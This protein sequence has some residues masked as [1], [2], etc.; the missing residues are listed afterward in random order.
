MVENTSD[1]TTLCDILSRPNPVSFREFIATSETDLISR[2]INGSSNPSE[3]KDLDKGI[4][5]RI[6]TCKTRSNWTK[7]TGATLHRG[8][9]RRAEDIKSMG[10]VLSPTVK[11]TSSGMWI[12]GKGKYKS[13]YK[14]QSWTDNFNIARKFSGGLMFRG[15]S[16][17][18][19]IKPGYS[20]WM[21]ITIP[22]PDPD[23]TFSVPQEWSFLGEREVVLFNDKTINVDVSLDLGH[24]VHAVWHGYEKAISLSSMAAVVGLNNAK[25]LMKS[26]Q[27]KD[28]VNSEWN[29]IEWIDR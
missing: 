17:K 5:D 7:S 18:A 28:A 11:Q 4:I 6:V 13:K 10:I 9:I 19:N 8:L 29:N 26:K 23:T 2:W 25:T 21:V 24:L 3:R 20:L 15:G 1:K 12:E 22:P 27:F 14:A 16:G